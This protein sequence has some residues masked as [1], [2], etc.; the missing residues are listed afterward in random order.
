METQREGQK[1]GVIISKA[2]MIL[3]IR[4]TAVF[5]VYSAKKQIVRLAMIIA[6]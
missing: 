6:V 1:Q 2:V 4:S 5:F 3:I